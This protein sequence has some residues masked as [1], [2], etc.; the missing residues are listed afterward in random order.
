MNIN[1]LL[2]TSSSDEVITKCILDNRHKIGLD[3]EVVTT[4]DLLENYDIND[5]IND[6][7]TIIRWIKPDGKVITNKDMVLLNRVV[8][9]PDSLFKNFVKQDR[10]YARSEF[11]AYIGF[12]FNAFDGIDNK[13]YDGVCVTMHSLPEQWLKVEDIENIII[14]DFYWGPKKLCPYR[15]DENYMCTEVGNLLNWQ[16]SY[17]IDSLDNVFFFK[18]PGGIAIFTITIGTKTIVESGK[19]LSNNIEYELIKLSQ[20][21]RNKFNYFIFETLFF[22]N[23]QMITFGCINHE[24]IKMKDDGMFCNFICENLIEELGKCI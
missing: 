9:I 15:S 21:I 19:R 10:C 16:K 17:I 4:R 1:N 3:I 23:E 14:P 13:S 12:A 6:E 8:R 22:I 2:I 18:K 11:S 7:E 5:E 20:K 24:I